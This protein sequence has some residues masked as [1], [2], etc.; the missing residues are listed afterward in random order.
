ML[1]SGRGC[2]FVAG[3]EGSWKRSAVMPTAV[4][5]L[6]HAVHGTLMLKVAMVTCGIAIA[7]TQASVWGGPSTSVPSLSS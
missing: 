1:A 7:R 5:A 6:P 3:V 4:V 2:Q